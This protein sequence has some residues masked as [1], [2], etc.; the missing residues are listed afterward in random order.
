MFFTLN[1]ERSPF[2]QWRLQTDG[3]YRKLERSSDVEP[4]DQRFMLPGDLRR[5]Y[6]TDVKANFN[7]NEIVANRTSGTPGEV[8][9]VFQGISH[10]EEKVRVPAEI[11]LMH[12]LRGGNDNRHNTLVLTLDGHFD[13]LDPG[14][15]D[16]VYN[17]TIAARTETYA[18][19]NGY[20][21]PEAASMT[22]YVHGVYRDMLALWVEHVETGHLNIHDDIGTEEPEADLLARLEAFNAQW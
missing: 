17:P 16:I 13:L 15:V 1:L 22:E 4:D 21:G 20:V 12:L 8:S 5:Y 7:G 2:E 11:E 18:A 19:G 14:E 10:R 6:R 9:Y 3:T